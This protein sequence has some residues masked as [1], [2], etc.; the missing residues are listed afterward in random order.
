MFYIQFIEQLEKRGFIVHEGLESYTLVFQDK[1]HKT[2]ELNNVL[3]QLDKSGD[4]IHYRFKKTNPEKSNRDDLVDL[5]GYA[6]N[7]KKLND[8]Y[9]GFINAIKV[10]ARKNARF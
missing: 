2:H 5:T 9:A 1:L 10:I 7:F 3:I 8:T 6:D 4:S